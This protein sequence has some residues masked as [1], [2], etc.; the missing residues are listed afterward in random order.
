MGF[1]K[2]ACPTLYSTLYSTLYL[3]ES[4]A[5][6]LE[7]VWQRLSMGFDSFEVQQAKITERQCDL[8]L[9]TGGMVIQELVNELVPWLKTLPISNLS[10]HCQ[11]V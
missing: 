11:G 9:L 7:Q 2:C 6:T 5:D 3:D 8:Q 4:A 1:L 10:Y